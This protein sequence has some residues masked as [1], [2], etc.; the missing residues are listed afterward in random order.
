MIGT[1]AGRFWNKRTSGDH[2]ND[3]IVDI[4]YNTKKSTGNWRDLLPLRLQ[5]K[6]SGNAAVKIS[7]MKKNNYNMRVTA[8]QMVVGVLWTGL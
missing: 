5:W 7:Q 3:S 8:K 6:P 1:E 4:G 2:L